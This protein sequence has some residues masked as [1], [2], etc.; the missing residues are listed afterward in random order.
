MDY[1]V[2]K[3]RFPCSGVECSGILY[4]PAGDGV[5]PAV[6]MANGFG[7]VKEVHVDDYAPYWASRGYVVLSFDFRRLGESGGTPRQ[8]IYPEDQVSDYR[9][10]ISYIRGLDYVD[11]DRICV[12]GTSFSGGHVITLLAFPPKGVRC[13]IAQVPNVYT[14]KTAM[15]YFGS[16]DPVL[17]L[18]DT[19]REACCRG[20]F[21]K[22]V[23]PIVSRDGPAVI[24]S[25][26]AVEYYLE[27][28][29]KYPTFRNYVTLDSLD[30]VLAYNPGFYAELVSRP[31]LFVIAEKD[32]TTPPDLALDVA[33]RIRS[34]KRVVRY[35]AG[36]FDI[37]KQPLVREVARLELEW[38]NMHLGGPNA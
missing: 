3:V 21:E 22:A 32:E 34:D 9:C 27:H 31:I 36:H 12:W 16:L 5:Y 23:I 30:R 26:E 28:V 19:G 6:V 37:Y 14:F 11:P 24:T 2:E 8:A 29:A 13:G 17:E 18:A 35:L 10:A 33:S 25:R 20:D 15:K 38:L 7:V 1:T 4:R